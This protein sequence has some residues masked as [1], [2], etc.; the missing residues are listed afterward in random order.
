MINSLSVHTPTASISTGVVQTITS[1]VTL[2]ALLSLFDQTEARR[3]QPSYLEYTTCDHY[4]VCEDECTTDC[5]YY[6]NFFGRL[7]EDCI[8][9]CRP[10]CWTESDCY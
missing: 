9:T 8:Q 7:I 5:D 10:V 4:E 3:H 6:Y 2:V 1:A